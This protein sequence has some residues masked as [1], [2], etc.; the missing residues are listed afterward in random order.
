MSELTFEELVDR[1]KREQVFFFPENVD[2][3]VYSRDISGDS[4]LHVACI[5]GIYEEVSLLIAIGANINE[6]GEM[7]YTPL[8]YAI[9]KKNLE[10]VDLLL[11]C[12]ADT[13]IKN[14]FGKSVIDT[15]DPEVVM[16]LQKYN[17]K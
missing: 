9:S 11:K 14:S 10:I 1:Y 12:G 5:R 15:H 7:S 17:Q 8:H 13:T 3:S 16:L 6:T 2:I 4:L